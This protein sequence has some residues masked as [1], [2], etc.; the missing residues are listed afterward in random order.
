VEDDDRR[1]PGPKQGC[2]DR[3][4]GTVT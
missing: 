4:L 2:E 3:E 1:N